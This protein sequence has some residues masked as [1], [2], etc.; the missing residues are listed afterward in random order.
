MISRIR[1]FE[2][3]GK[4]LLFVGIIKGLVS[5]RDLLR[6]VVE[7]FEPEL[8]L[9][10]ISPE[11]LKGM[12]EYLKKPFEIHPDDYEVIYALKLEK[13]GEVGMPVPA[14][15]EAFAISRKNGI[16]IVPL[17]I[18][19]EEYS[20][21]YLRKVEFYHIFLAN[22][23]KK[24]IAKKEFQAK[25]PEDFVLLWDREVNKITPF[26]EIEEE[27]EKYMGRRIRE[28][29]QTRKERRL[30]V[31]LELERLQGVLSSLNLLHTT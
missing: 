24:K 7:E 28:I 6:T 8:L 30:L 21:L 5:E 2:M 14:Y 18:P 12:K 31:I 10:G 26:R 25:N 23:R 20:D 29:L 13:F 15:L 1:K 3:N 17:D 22:R 11:E 4:K 27:R 9:I 16:E 19:E